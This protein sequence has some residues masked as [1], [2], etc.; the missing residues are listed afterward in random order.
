M[1]IFFDVRWTRT[2]THFGVSRYGAH[3]AEAL[4]KIHPITMIINDERQLKLLPKNVPYVKLNNPLSPSEL[5]ISYKLNRLGA[6]VVYS[7]MQVM[8]NL[9]RKYKLILTLHDLIYYSHPTPPKDLPWWVRAGWRVFHTVYWP[10]RILLN[11]ADRVTTV[12]ETVKKEIIQHG[13][14]DKPVDVVYNAPFEA[15]TKKPTAHKYKKELVYMGNFIPYKN[16]ELLIKAMELLPDYKLHLVSFISLQREAQLKALVKNLTQVKFWR[17]ISDQQYSELLHTSAALVT[18]SKA[19]GFGIPIIEAMEHGTPV[20]CSDI[21]ILHEVAS[22]AALYFNPDSAEEFT[23]QV[24]KLEKETLRKKLIDLGY[25]QSE[26]FSWD[27]SA[28]ELMQA[29]TKL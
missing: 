3:L 1:N 5:F 10:Q 8:G 23:T 13:L 26:K 19:E 6:D 15:I 14:T 27:K 4:A 2:D 17:G 18:A 24:R 25:R 7:P 12:S 20:I 11:H 28:K 29:I 16:A 21:P 9:G 22:N